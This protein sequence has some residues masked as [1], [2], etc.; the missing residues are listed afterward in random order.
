MSVK[1]SAVEATK[2]GAGFM[3]DAVKLGAKTMVSGVKL[4]W[5]TSAS[6]VGKELK[7]RKEDKAMYDKAYSA[8]RLKALEHQGMRDGFAS[9]V[10]K[11]PVKP[12]TL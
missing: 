3:V 2:K 7:K 12:K 4:G 6:Y 10:P 9:T 11:P 1:D 5:D 8:S